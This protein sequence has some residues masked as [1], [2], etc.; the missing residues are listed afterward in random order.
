MSGFVPV[1]SARSTMIS[2]PGG[3]ELRIPSSRNW[4]VV[5]F[6]AL[7][8]CGWVFGEFNV[9]RELQH[10]A[11]NAPVAFMA[12]WIVGWTVGGFFALATLAWLVAGREHVTIAGDEFAV[13]REAFGIG[14]TRRYELRNAKNLRVFDAPVDAGPFG[15]RDPYGFRSGPFVFD[16]GPRSIRFGVGLDV[17]EARATLARILAAKPALSSNH[18]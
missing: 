10:P 15:M 16:Y 5:F 12:F 11:E 1:A 9:V 6:L 13:R 8:L 2:V 17:A 3:I 18:G 14:W 7:W 4:F